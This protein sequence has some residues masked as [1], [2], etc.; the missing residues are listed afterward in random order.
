MINTCPRL[1]ETPKPTQ[2]SDTIPREYAGQKTCRHAMPLGKVL[3]YQHFDPLY[4]FFKINLFI[5]LFWLHCIFVAVRGLSLVVVS[6]G[7][8]PLRCTVFSLGWPLLL[9]STG[10]RHVGFSSCGTRAQ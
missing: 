2:E 7:Y 5:Y 6:G 3:M 9:Q 8:S 10:S 1:R 4:S